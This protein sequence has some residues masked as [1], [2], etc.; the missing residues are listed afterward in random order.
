MVHAPYP[1]PYRC[2]FDHSERECGEDYIDYIKDYIFK[3]D[4]SPDEIA[5]IVLEPVQGEGGYIVPP[6]NFIKGIR[7]IASENGIV[8]VADEIQSGYFRTGK[9]LA[10]ENFGV[11]ADIYTMAKAL[12]GG[13]PIGATITRSSLGDIPAGSH[14]NTFGG[15]LVSI[16]AANASL[17]Y[18]IKNRKQLE[19]GVKR[20][21]EI[22]FK[23]LHEMQN[24]YEIIGDVRGI[25][26]MIGIE[27]VKSRKTKEHAIKERAAIVKSAFDKGLVLLTCGESSM[28]IIPPLTINESSLQSG[29]DILESAIKENK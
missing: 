13:L 19:A 4:V 27:L 6:K 5:A 28:R 17:N 16:A 23:R 24:N 22:V 25:G 20:K 15:N 18:A 10:M 12:G 9:F 1:Y 2:P 11:E 29:L 3:K 26:L 21:S 7:K 14:A 8:L